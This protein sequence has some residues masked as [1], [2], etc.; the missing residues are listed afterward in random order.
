MGVF[1][2]FR[3]LVLGDVPAAVVAGGGLAEAGVAVERAAAEE[4]FQPALVLGREVAGVFR[5]VHVAAAAVA[6]GGGQAR[7]QRG[8]VLVGPAADLTRAVAQRAGRAHLGR[9]GLA[10][11]GALVGEFIQ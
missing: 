8:V 4:L 3:V 10:D 7:Q 6:L 2:V 5:Q 11:E 1:L 9:D